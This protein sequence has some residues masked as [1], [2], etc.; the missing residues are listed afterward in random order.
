MS[1]SPQTKVNAG[2]CGVGTAPKVG[3]M[4]GSDGATPLCHVGMFL[5]ACFDCR[6]SLLISLRVRR[7]MPLM[8]RLE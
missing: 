4:N 2:M 3:Y 6:R 1:S 7:C 8:E 5:G